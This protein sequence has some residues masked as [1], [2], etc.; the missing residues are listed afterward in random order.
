MV[1]LKRPVAA[2]NSL[3]FLC[4]D[5][6]FSSD[7]DWVEPCSGAPITGAVITVRPIASIAEYHFLFFI[8]KLLFRGQTS[9]QS[10]PTRR[11]SLW[12]FG[13]IEKPSH[14]N[15]LQQRSVPLCLLRHQLAR[16]AIR[17]SRAKPLPVS[18]CEF[19][20]PNG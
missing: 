1:T 9:R 17:T 18:I 16:K 6:A 4:M 2:R 11:P 14:Q 20:H 3:I 5:M 8:T 7:G 13:T 19:M 15:S 12:Y 10:N